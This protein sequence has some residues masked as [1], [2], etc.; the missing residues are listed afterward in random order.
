MKIGMNMLLWADHVTEQHYPLI[1]K[2]K[3]AG[4]DGIELP[5]G[6]GDVS[7][8]SK[9]GNH[10]TEIERGRFRKTTEI[11]CEECLVDHENEE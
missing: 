10:L 6:N 2:I 1:D 11:L 7:H 4:F 9:L 3:H 8:Y 5:L